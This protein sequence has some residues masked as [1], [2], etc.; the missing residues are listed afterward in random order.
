MEKIRFDVVALAHC[1]VRD[2]Y[3]EYATQAVGKLLTLQRQTENVEDRYAIRVREKALHIGYVAVTDQER[4]YQAMKG[5]GGQ[6]LRAKVVESNPDPPVLTMEAEV[7]KVDWDYNPFDDSPFEGWHYDGISLIPPKMEKLGDLAADIIDELEQGVV[8]P[9]DMQRMVGQLLES[10]LYDVSREMASERYRIERLLAVQEDERLREMAVQLR[11]QKG[12]LMRHIYRDQV[13]RYLFIE[14]PTRL[15]QKGLEQSHYTHDN[16]LDQLERQLRSFPFLLYEKFLSDPVDFLREVY[17]NHVPRQHLF[18]LLSGII[19][20]ILKGR[21]SIKSWGRDGDTEPLEQIQALAQPL[22]QTDREQAIKE[23]LRELLYKKDAREH[24][25]MC[26]KNQWAAVMS[27]L[28]FEYNL[29]EIDMKAFC[30]KMD[31][32]GFGEDGDCHC[33]CD[34]DSL[35]KSSDYATRP[36]QNWRGTG[37]AHK[38]QVLAA[39]ELRQILRPKIGWR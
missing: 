1:D 3:K 17:Y 9:D 6:R 2:N 29:T 39:T 8:N 31:E 32:W 33:P 27:V 24:L 4:V 13:A 26:Q 14:L 18:P 19:L 11:H 25:V 15:R 20:M 38:R 22:C 34:Y 35:S 7:E 21:V 37:I 28:V 12:M 30:R 10:N 36:F 5:S 23:S 16:R